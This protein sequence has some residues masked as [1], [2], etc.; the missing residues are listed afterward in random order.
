[1][2]HNLDRQGDTFCN[3]ETDVAQQWSSI[4]HSPTVAVHALAEHLLSPMPAAEAWPPSPQTICD[5]AL[6]AARH[7][8][9]VKGRVRPEDA[10]E[11]T[12]LLA[13][14]VEA[15][16]GRRPVA[17]LSSYLDPL[18]RGDIEARVR[19]VIRTQP[20]LQIRSVHLATPAC[21]VVEACGTL[22]QADRAR[23]LAARFEA[24]HPGWLCMALRLG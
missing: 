2:E 10:A 6:L 13:A 5:P 4:G 1:M 14:I 21:G 18:V 12:W 3:H 7:P 11:T 16:N 24:N 9:N 15:L 17:Q 22:T 20:G 8:P 23:A 19:G